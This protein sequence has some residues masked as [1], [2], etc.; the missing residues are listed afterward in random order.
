MCVRECVCVREFTCV[1]VRIYLDTHTCACRPNIPVPLE[2]LLGTFL[3]EQG[4]K[5]TQAVQLEMS[6]HKVLYFLCTG[7]AFLK[8]LYC[9]C[10]IFFFLC[11]GGAFLKVLYCLCFIFYFFFIPSAPGVESRAGS[12]W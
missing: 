10:F 12:G 5:L 8:V 6:L 9:L 11:T 2:Q 1:C 7:G 3:I 4:K